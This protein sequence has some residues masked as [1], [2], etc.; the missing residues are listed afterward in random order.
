[1]S[2]DMKCVFLILFL[3][4][5]SSA[6]FFFHLLGNKR[7]YLRL[8][9]ALCLKIR[10]NHLHGRTVCLVQQIPANSKT[11]LLNSIKINDSLDCI[12]PFLAYIH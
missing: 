11:I 7:C 10:Q 8:L 5:V 6:F 3:Y 9:V 2:R 12:F 1:M 4:F